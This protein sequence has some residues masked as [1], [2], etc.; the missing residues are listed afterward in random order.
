MSL[1][2]HPLHLCAYVD[3][4]HFKQTPLHLLGLTEQPKPKPQ[5]DWVEVS[6]CSDLLDSAG[7]EVW[8]GK[9]ATTKVPTGSRQKKAMK[10]TVTSAEKGQAGSGFSQLHSNL[11][12]TRAATGSEANPTAI[13]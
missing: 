6:F 4:F 12:E 13:M 1:L 9:S 10:Q 8:V 2:G 3:Y 7:T 5:F 11:K